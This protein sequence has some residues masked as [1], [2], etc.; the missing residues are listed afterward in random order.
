MM[1]SLSI[2]VRM[3]SFSGLCERAHVIDAVVLEKCLITLFNVRFKVREQIWQQ[4]SIWLDK[5]TTYLTFFFLILPND[6]SN[7]I[8]T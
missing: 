8:R 6:M 4:K 5:E 3:M 1:V 2:L 7:M